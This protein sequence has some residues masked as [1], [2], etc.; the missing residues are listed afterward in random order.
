M[1]TA[2]AY[3]SPTFANNKSK[4]NRLKRNSNANNS[5]SKKYKTNTEPPPTPNTTSSSEVISPNKTSD[6]TTDVASESG[7][8][9]TIA[10]QN[11]INDP[12][13]NAIN[14]MNTAINNQLNYSEDADTQDESTFT[15]EVAPELEVALEVV[16][17]N[18]NT[19]PVPNAL[20]LKFHVDLKQFLFDD[21][22]TTNKQLIKWVDI[23]NKCSDVYDTIEDLDSHKQLIYNVISSN[24]AQ[25]DNL[26]IKYNGTLRI[27]ARDPDEHKL[28]KKL[29]QYKINIYGR[30]RK[31]AFPAA[32]NTLIEGKL[33]KPQ[34]I[35]PEI[36]LIPQ[37][38][39]ETTTEL[40]LLHLLKL[41]LILILLLVT[42]INLK[43]VILWQIHGLNIYKILNG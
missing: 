26:I 20:Q 9:I 31:Q 32:P 10:N 33:H 12:I 2:T 40:L 19:L 3:A 27:D 21:I 23:S 5:P 14:S 37:P 35:Q 8:E 4:L 1:S 42:V 30:I 25:L 43:L 17:N 7:S 38:V 13:N 29:N 36:Q 15:P 22:Q 16:N 24:I 34:A 28:Y 18:R 6:D 11:E 39:S 41:H